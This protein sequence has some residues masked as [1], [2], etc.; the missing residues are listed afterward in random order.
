MKAKITLILALATLLA[1]LGRSQDEIRMDPVRM[2]YFGK[3][4]QLVYFGVLEGLFRDGVTTGEVDLILT[5][6]E[7]GHYVHFI[8]ACPICMATIH[9]LEL[10]RERP[11][12]YGIKDFAPPAKFRTFGPGLSDEVSAK[13]ISDDVKIRLAVIHE[14]VGGWVNERLTLLQLTE[15]EKANLQAELEAGRERG[16]SMLKSYQN[17]GEEGLKIYAPAYGDLNEC[18]VCNAALQMDF[19]TE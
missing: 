6:S 15:D 3:A 5:K 16:M 9:A 14:L 17:K 19:K 18:A 7:S 11:R 4:Y 10:Y 13:L 2:D 12:F 8:Y 1:S